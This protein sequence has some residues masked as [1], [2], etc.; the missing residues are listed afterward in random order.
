MSSKTKHG[1]RD[2]K[3]KKTV[4]SDKYSSILLDI[5]EIYSHTQVALWWM[6]VSIKSHWQLQIFLK[7]V[8][9]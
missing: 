1:G 3:K 7:Y 2:N 9:E 8:M 6:T 5:E 4:I